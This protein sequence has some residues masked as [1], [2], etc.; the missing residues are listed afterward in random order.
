M[1][2]E[3]WGAEKC[4]VVGSGVWCVDFGDFDLKIYSFL[5]L[6]FRANRT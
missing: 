4:S 1:G 6:M 5:T 2:R 3:K